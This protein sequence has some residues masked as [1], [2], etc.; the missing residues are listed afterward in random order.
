MMILAAPPLSVL[1][2]T[3]G[4]KRV[5]QSNYRGAICK[6]D[7]ISDF[8]AQEATTKNHRRR[9]CE[10]YDLCKEL[11]PYKDAWSW[12]KSIV[13]S[14]H[15][16]ME[17][18]EDHSDTLII[19]QHLPVYTLGTGSLEEYLNFE[20]ENAPFDVY[21]TERGGEVTYH[22]PGQIVVYPIINLRHHKMDLHWYLRSLEELVI[23]VLSSTFSIQASRLEGL[24]GVWVGNQ[25]VAAIGIRVSR[26]IT[27]HGLALNV[28]T[29]LSPFQHIVPCGIRDRGVGSISGVLSSS[30]G[31][32]IT[33][34][35]VHKDAYQ[36]MD[37]THKSL[38]REFSEIF[39]LTLQ[40][41]S[42]SDLDLYN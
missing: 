8:D 2:P 38:L 28:N 7:Q 19:L 3:R 21:R 4:L 23:R 33:K 9:R 15:A 37:I 40:H 32:K 24:T 12:Q 5:Y 41:K 10:C 25:K 42:I 1:P 30:S 18:D 16:L 6:I 22:G 36:L 31:G 20:I 11:V 35:T 26:W 34:N 17:R 13:R 27:Y 14:R 29:D 39:Q